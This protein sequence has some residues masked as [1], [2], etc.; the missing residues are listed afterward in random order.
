[1]GEGGGGREEDGCRVQ[2][3]GVGREG[4]EARGMDG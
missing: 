3:A 4:G 1:M 2:W